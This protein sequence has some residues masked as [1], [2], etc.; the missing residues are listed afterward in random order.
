MK[1]LGPDTSYPGLEAAV[2][3]GFPRS[4]DYRRAAVP[5]RS[6]LARGW[7][8]EHS[9]SLAWSLPL[10][11]GTAA[12]R[13]ASPGRRWAFFTRYKDPLQT[14]SQSEGTR[15][16]RQINKERKKQREKG[17]NMKTK[18]V[19]HGLTA[20]TVAAATMVAVAPAQAADKKPN[21]LFIMGDD[22]GW[23]QVGCYQQGLMVGETPNIDRLAAEGGRF[24]TYYAESSCTAGRRPSSPA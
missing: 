1:S 8:S 24:L 12:L 9:G 7:V 22:I 14:K 16:T 2:R 3:S 20:L 23:M 11:L 17:G 21:I 5:S 4:P 19:K 10:R 13:P 15:Q 6:T 18:L